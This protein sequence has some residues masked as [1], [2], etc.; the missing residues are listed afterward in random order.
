MGYWRI[1]KKK[2]IADGFKL[3]STDKNVI[4]KVTY[5]EE[6]YSKG[7]YTIVVRF[8]SNRYTGARLYINGVMQVDMSGNSNCFYIYDKL[9]L[10]GVITDTEDL[11]TF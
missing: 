8:V 9:I 11:I 4:D 1:L 6:N 10:D 7:L 2:V 5:R 3:I